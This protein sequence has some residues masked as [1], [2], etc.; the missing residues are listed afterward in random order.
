MYGDF[1]ESARDYVN[2]LKVNQRYTRAGVFKAP[3][4]QEQIISIARA[5]YAE[6][7]NYAQIITSVANSVRKQIANIITPLQ[8]NAPFIPVLIAGVII[9]LFIFNN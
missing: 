5:G 3:N 2:F 6:A 9:T 4:Y 7:P 8:N 1:E